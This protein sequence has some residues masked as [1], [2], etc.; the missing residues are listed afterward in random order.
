MT[1]NSIESAH[2]QP[3]ISKY[4]LPNRKLTFVNNT[5]TTITTSLGISIHAMLKDEP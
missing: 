5:Q 1:L 2:F 4:D 3:C